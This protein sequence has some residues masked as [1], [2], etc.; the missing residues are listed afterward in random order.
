MTNYDLSNITE[1]TY[2]KLFVWDSYWGTTPK[3]NPITL[4]TENDMEI[5]VNFMYDNSYT[6]KA[7]NRGETIKAQVN[8]KSTKCLIRQRSLC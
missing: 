1:N 5:S 4:F 6:E 7:F 8:A 2:I 3:A